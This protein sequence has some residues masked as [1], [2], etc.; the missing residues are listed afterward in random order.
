[1]NTAAH[2]VA[3]SRKSGKGWEREAILC[4]VNN[5]AEGDVEKVLSV[6]HP[7]KN[8]RPKG[9][10]CCGR[11]ERCDKPPCSSVRMTKQAN[12]ATTQGCPYNF[13]K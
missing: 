1:M 8:P 4:S 6:S 11:E 12:W 3:A 13:G 5:V 9:S 10:T 2:L 7:V